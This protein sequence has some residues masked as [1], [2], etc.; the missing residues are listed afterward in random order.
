MNS[1]TEQYSE[2]EKRKTRALLSVYFESLGQSPADGIHEL[3]AKFLK[4][5]NVTEAHKPMLDKIVRSQRELKKKEKER[6]KK[7][8]T[9]TQTQKHY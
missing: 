9:S 3:H 4:E 8:E 7:Y 1:L 5:N 2:A 6:G